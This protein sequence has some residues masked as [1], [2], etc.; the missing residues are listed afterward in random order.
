MIVTQPQIYCRKEFAAIE[1]CQYT[2]NCRQRIIGN[3]L[4]QTLISFNLASC[5]Y[6]TI[7]F[8]IVNAQSQNK[9]TILLPSVLLLVCTCSSF[10]GTTRI[11]HT[12]SLMLLDIMPV[13]YNC[14]ISL[15]TH[16]HTSRACCKAWRQ[17]GDPL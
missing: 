1:P 15:P 16:S 17:M 14:L 5:L 2:I 10:L 3:D 4:T 9:L 8:P 6:L 13:S 7:E 11:G 12:Q